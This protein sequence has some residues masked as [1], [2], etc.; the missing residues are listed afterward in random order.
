MVVSHR[1]NFEV[2]TLTRGGG[3]RGLEAQGRSQGLGLLHH[4]TNKISMILI[5]HVNR[6]VIVETTEKPK[7]LVSGSLTIKKAGLLSTDFI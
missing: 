2:D 6:G 1:T 3:G 7:L 4:S 5:I